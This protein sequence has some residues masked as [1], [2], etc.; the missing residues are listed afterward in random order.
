[1]PRILVQ[2]VFSTFFKGIRAL[3]PG[4]PNGTMFSLILWMLAQSTLSD[5]PFLLPNASLV[6]LHQPEARV[7]GLLVVKYPSNSVEELV[8]IR[9]IKKVL[10]DAVEIEITA[11]QYLITKFKADRQNN[12]FEYLITFSGDSPDTNATEQALIASERLSQLNASSVM[13][14]VAELWP[15]LCDNESSWGYSCNPNPWALT[16]M[17]QP[18]LSLWVSLATL[19]TTESQGCEQRDGFVRVSGWRFFSV[20]DIVMNS[21]VEEFDEWRVNVSRGMQ[22]WRNALKAAIPTCPHGLHGVQSYDGNLGVS[23]I[24]WNQA[25]GSADNCGWG[26]DGW[27]SLCRGD[28]ETWSHCQPQNCSLVCEFK[29]DVQIELCGQSGGKIIRDALNAAFRLPSDFVPFLPS[30]RSYEIKYCKY[31]NVIEVTPD[32]NFFGTFA[33]LC[34]VRDRLMYSSPSEVSH[35]L[36][37]K[38]LAWKHFRFSN[39]SGLFYFIR[40]RALESALGGQ[41]EA[42]VNFTT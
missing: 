26:Y 38:G 30:V 17:S 33:H 14:S 10:A 37:Q 8:L 18:D 32:F 16:W 39:S 40:L 42:W 34:P 22:T 12:T 25:E 23:A 6:N 11:I 27:P 9:G 28:S 1:M 24:C 21:S 5:V 7:S 2:V 29:S 31:E 13:T 15:Q 41:R 35:I 3:H 20:N 4:E 19:A 36:L